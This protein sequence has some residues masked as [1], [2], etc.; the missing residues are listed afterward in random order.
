MNNMEEL[1][2]Y[3]LVSLAREQNEDAYY[4]LHEKYQPL[5]RKKSL[6]Y[7]KYLKNKGIEL[8]DLIQEC[9]IALEE[10]I[11]KFNS[12]DDSSFYTFANMCI[13]N[14]LMNE[15][16]KQNRIKYK[17]LNE[18]IPLED[19][20]ENNLINFIGDNS[21]NPELDILSNENFKE[22]YLTIIKELTDLEECVFKLKVQ[23]FTYKEISDILDKDDKSIYNTIQR[24]KIKIKSLL[25]KNN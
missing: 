24:I 18:S 2:D 19:E 11:Y 10:A 16:R 1:N 7:L 9:T 5:I 23:G 14:Q 13:D 8:T 22:L 25:S 21:N 17:T 6:K 3:E 4:M 15:I 12:N 20:N